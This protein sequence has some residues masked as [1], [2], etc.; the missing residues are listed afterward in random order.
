[1]RKYHAD[2]RLSISPIWRH[3]LILRANLTSNISS[4]A[5][6][7]SSPNRHVCTWR[8]VRSCYLRIQVL[9]KVRIPDPFSIAVGVFIHV[10]RWCNKFVSGGPRRS[11]VVN[12]RIPRSHGLQKRQAFRI[13]SELREGRPD[14][15]NRERCRRVPLHLARALSFARHKVAH[16]YL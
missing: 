12:S 7:C 5:R 6:T 8:N 3:L 4:K 10:H 2:R 13:L 14:Q 11:G 15:D 16:S 1:M 9:T